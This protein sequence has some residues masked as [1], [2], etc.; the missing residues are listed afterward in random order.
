MGS[1]NVLSRD[2]VCSSC[3]H[4]LSNTTSS[5]SRRHASAVAA[6]VEEPAQPQREV[7]QPAMATGPQKAFRLACSPVLS[8]PPLLTRELTSFEKAYYLYQKRL[9]ERLALP[10]T[11]YFYYK[12]GTPADIEWK[13]KAKAR[14]GVAARDVGLYNA[15]DEE[16]WNDEVLVGSRLGEPDEV[17]ER[18]I[19]DAEGKD[20]V[21]AKLQ[22]DADAG[23]LEISGDPKAGE[24]VRKPVGESA[25]ERPVARATDADQK[26]DTWSLN[27]RLDRSLYLLVKRKDGQWRF[28]EDRVYGR[29]NLHQAAERILIQAGGI[30]MNTWV[31]GNHPVGHFAAAYRKSPILSK[32]PANR[33]VSTSKEEL[34]QEEYGEKVFFMKSRIMAGQADIAK[35]ELGDQEFQWLTKEEIQQRVAP[36]YWSQ[37]KNMLTE[38]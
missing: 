34:E 25:V 23:K 8:R 5:T 18:L 29:E 32:I 3:R 2:T 28:P 33:L 17:A 6:V 11:R 19:R 16:G 15:Y 12:K 24:G 21:E 38:R 31:V 7:S 4:R 36:H 30:N 9:N 10:F 35:N 26:N 1:S 14:K 20:I 37:I 27:R 22:G 13:R